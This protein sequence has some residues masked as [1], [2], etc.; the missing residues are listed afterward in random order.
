ML[1]AVAALASNARLTAQTPTG[2][3]V[4]PSVDHV[5]IGDRIVMQ[6]II[7][8]ASGGVVAWPDSLP[9]I[10]P[11][12]Q[13]NT[14]V[15][16]E[17]TAIDNVV[18]SEASYVVAAFELGE[19]TFPAIDFVFI[20][21]TGDTI[22]LTSQPVPIVVATVGLE[23]S[24]DIRGIKPPLDIPLSWVIIGIWLAGVIVSLAG[25]LILYKRLM[26]QDRPVV[27][28]RRASPPKPPHVIAFEALDRV[29]QSSMLENQQIQPWYS[30]VS[31]IIRV[32]IGGRYGVH[33]MEM[34]TTDIMMALEPFRLEYRSLDQ[35]R[36]F[37]E[38]ADLVK[39][40]KH[41]PSNSACLALL[42]SARK[43]VDV[44]A[45]RIQAH[46]QTPNRLTQPRPRD[47]LSI[48][49]PAVLDFAQT[50]H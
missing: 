2:V 41:R 9:N 49:R 18:R 6:F 38:R 40:A 24:D 29:E 42:D 25:A 14:P 7:E 16:A 27:A 45:N 21:S 37:F 47:V 32:Y 26:K 39:F 13:I 11:F 43:L 44:T 46:R 5:T 8:H 31:Q 12:E 23:G 17:P 36:D 34:A 22:Q 10:T 48:C 35:F 19:L 3:V 15:V 28:K 33:A 30:E 4:T 20:E 1:S 50:L